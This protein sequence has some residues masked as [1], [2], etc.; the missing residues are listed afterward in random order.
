MPFTGRWT[1]VWGGGL[2][3][4]DPVDQRVLARW[5][6]PLKSPIGLLLK[7]LG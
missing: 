4:L 7:I 3:W 5:I 1:R 6:L 2:G